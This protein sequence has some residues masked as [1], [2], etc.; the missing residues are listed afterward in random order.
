M[1]D[2]LW[3]VAGEVATHVDLFTRSLVEPRFQEMGHF[4]VW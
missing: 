3:M 2:G 4:Q 1:V